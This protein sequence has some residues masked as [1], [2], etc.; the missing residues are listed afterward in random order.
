MKEVR[1]PKYH[2]MSI[3]TCERPEIVSMIPLLLGKRFRLSAS[4]A[5]R[6]SL[7]L[8]AFV[9]S[10]ENHYA[11]ITI[12]PQRHGRSRGMARRRRNY[13]TTHHKGGCSFSF[14]FIEHKL[15]SLM[16]GPSP[17]K[18]LAALF[19]QWVSAANK[20]LS[21]ALS[22]KGALLPCIIIPPISRLEIE[23]REGD[24]GL[25]LLYNGCPLLGSMVAEGEVLALLARNQNQYQYQYQVTIPS[26][27][28]SLP[29]TFPPL[30]LTYSNKTTPPSTN[31][32]LSPTSPTSKQGNLLIPTLHSATGQPQDP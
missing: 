16:A 23:E 2:R 29:N 7:C 25:F 1:V 10:E 4:I 13:K 17:R 18:K 19:F 30:F 22:K 9:D 28:L 3:T 26:R 27:A 20:S 32:P 15:R 11:K 24:H 21:F 31:P 14:L 6:S 12:S 8:S 5:G